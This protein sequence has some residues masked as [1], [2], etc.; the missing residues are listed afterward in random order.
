M[1]FSCSFTGRNVGAIGICHEV[2][3]YVDA[4]DIK[5][6]E[7]KLYDEFEHISDLIINY[8][9]MRDAISKAEGKS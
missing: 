3:T 9:A 2:V 8:D 7:L 5:A 6:A 1:R 4:P